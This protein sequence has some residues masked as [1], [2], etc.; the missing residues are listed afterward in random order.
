MIYKV[1]S[2]LQDLPVWIAQL[3][4]VHAYILTENYFIRFSG[5][6]KVSLLRIHFMG[7]V[8][9]GRACMDLYTVAIT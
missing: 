8:I 4:E 2:V 6:E 5:T 7:I 1:V 9:I 3:K